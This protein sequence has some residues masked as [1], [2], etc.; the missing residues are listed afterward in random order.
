MVLGLTTRLEGEYKEETLELG[1]G[2]GLVLYTDGVTE[3]INEE[4]EQFQLER[5]VDSVERHLEQPPR[6][7]L[8]GVLGEVLR[9][10]GKATQRDDITLLVIKRTGGPQSPEAVGGEETSP[11]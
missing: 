4:G 6:Q 10:K 5:L 3:A 7:A 2:D 8:H 11:R 1:P 9:F